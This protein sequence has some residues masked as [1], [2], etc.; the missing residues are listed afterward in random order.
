MPHSSGRWF[1]FLVLQELQAVTTLRPVVVAAPGERDQVVP[2][3][4]FAVA[5]IGLAPVAVLAAVAI[6]SEEECV[7][8][9]AAEAAGNVDEFDEPDDRWF[10][11]CQAFAS[12]DV[13]GIRFDDLGFAL[14][15]QT[16]GSPDRDHGQ[17][18]ERGVQ[19]QAPHALLRN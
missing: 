18:L 19:R 6:A 15:D 7:G 12:D 17:R 4:A 16:E 14:D 1:P 2:G 3:E 8:D 10:G 5:Q 9:L 11:K 13:T